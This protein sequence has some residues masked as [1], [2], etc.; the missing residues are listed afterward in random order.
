MSK[1]ILV[2][3]A[4][5]AGSTAGVAE[6]IAD[7]IRGTVPA[8]EQ[9]MR[10]DATPPEIPVD[11]RD[12]SSV[13]DLRPYSAVVIGSSIRLGRWL[14]EAVAFLQAISWGAPA[15]AL[16]FCLR[17]LSEGVA[18]TVP[19]MVVGGLGLALL[20]PLGYA[21]MFGAGLGA[22]GLGYAVATVL[23]CQAMLVLLPWVVSSP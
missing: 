2:A 1:R 3:Y 21:L 11:V 8:T 14:P 12:V 5:G 15:L 6:A 19:S 22:A 13:D 16:F 17:N 4:T 10:P 23:W 18:W 7:E 20:A 9:S